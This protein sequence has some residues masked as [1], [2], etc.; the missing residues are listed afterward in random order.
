MRSIW[1]VLYKCI[2]DVYFISVCYPP[3]VRALDWGLE[4]GELIDVVGIQPSSTIRFP[5]RSAN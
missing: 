5:L 4:G 1:Y 2:L 3:V